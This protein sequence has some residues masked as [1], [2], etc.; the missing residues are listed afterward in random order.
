MK[1]ISAFEINLNGK[2]RT[3]KSL[4]CFRRDGKVGFSLGKKR[5]RHQANIFYGDVIDEK[6]TIF[7]PEWEEMSKTS[8]T[9][10]ETTSVTVSEPSSLSD[11]SYPIKGILV[12]RVGPYTWVRRRP[13]SLTERLTERVAKR[14]V[15]GVCTD[16]LIPLGAKGWMSRLKSKSGEEIDITYDSHTVLVFI[17][18][19]RSVKQQRLNFH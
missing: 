5:T 17:E 10:R 8:G 13:E 1:E 19:V 15:I 12:L 6:F 9:Y 7:F 3:V 4:R 18:P 14:K 11:P 16:Y 2:N